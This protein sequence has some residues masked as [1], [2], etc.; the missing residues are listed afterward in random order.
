VH[1]EQRHLII[2]DALSLLVELAGL[3]QELI[4]DS[5]HHFISTELGR[6]VGSSERV[7]QLVEDETPRYAVH[8]YHEVTSTITGKEPLLTLGSPL[9]R[10]SVSAIFIAVA[11]LRE[12]DAQPL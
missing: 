5:V 6:G 3:S 4:H 1:P 2:I 9:Q 10:I 7:G 11:P 8:E 12:A